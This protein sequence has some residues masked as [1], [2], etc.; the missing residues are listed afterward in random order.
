MCQKFACVHIN[1]WENVPL[2]FFEEHDRVEKA[3]RIVF[4]LAVSSARPRNVI[5][6]ILMR[7]ENYVFIKHQ[8]TPTDARWRSRK[9]YAVAAN[10]KMTDYADV[11][12]ARGVMRLTE[13]VYG[14]R[15]H[16]E[17]RPPE[18]HERGKNAETGGRCLISREPSSGRFSRSKTHCY[19]H[20]AP[21]SS[22]NFHGIPIG[23][24]PYSRSGISNALC[25]IQYH[26]A[27]HF[28]YLC[29]DRE[30]DKKYIFFF[31]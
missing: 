9:F 14:V 7:S 21:R 5:V 17:R 6:C 4:R 8:F 2:P 27:R 22:R 23:F 18:E 24:A 3:V 25:I 20:I 19:W 31:C 29:A 12:V 28:I 30:V 16:G 10:P 1:L 26:I 13:R 11:S 15:I